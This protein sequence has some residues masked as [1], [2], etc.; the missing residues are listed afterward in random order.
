MPANL[1]SARLESAAM[2]RVEWLIDRGIIEPSP[3]SGD[4]IR[5]LRNE[6]SGRQ[7]EEPQATSA[8]L[9]EAFDYGRP[10]SRMAIHH[11]EDRP[12]A[13]VQ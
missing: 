4:A 10:V 2:R 11:Q 5:E 13:V 7:E 8:G 9:Q 1:E 12:P 6:R 3:R